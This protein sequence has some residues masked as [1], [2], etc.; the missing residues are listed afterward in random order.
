MRE[1]GEWFVS[2]IGTVFDAMVGVVKALKPSDLE[3]LKQMFGIFAGI[4]KRRR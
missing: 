3:M 4:A 2:P 1:G